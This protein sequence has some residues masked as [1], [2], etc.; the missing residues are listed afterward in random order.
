MLLKKMA[1]PINVSLHTGKNYFK[2]AKDSVFGPGSF[3]SGSDYRELQELL[4]RHIRNL[5]FLL[6]WSESA[7]PH[8]RA[9]PMLCTAAFNPRLQKHL[10]LTTL[11][12]AQLQRVLEEHYGTMRVPRS[13]PA[14]GRG[15]HDLQVR[16]RNV[17]EALTPTH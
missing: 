17:F 11:G 13:A 14:Q 1:N 3:L 7:P 8:I 12:E 6:T 16:T 15:G 5:R 10:R 2:Q 4:N 9:L